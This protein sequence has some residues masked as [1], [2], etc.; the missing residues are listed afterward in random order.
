MFDR[1]EIRVRSGDGG[2]G[3][4]SF[5]REKFAPFGGPDGGDGGRGGNVIIV[6]DASIANLSA[7][8][9][10]RLYRAEKGGHGKGKKKH[11]KNGENLILEVPKGTIALDT[12]RSFDE[13]LLAD[14]EQA[15][16]RVVLAR[17]GKGGLGNPHF[18][19]STNQA[20]RIAQKGD[21]GEELSLILELRLIA[22][23]GVIGFPNAGKSTLLTAASAA[24][25]KIA[26]YS[27]TTLEPAL[28]VVEVGLKS[29]VIAEIPGLIDGAHLG[30]GLGHDFLRHIMRTKIL[31]H[32]IDGS[33][34]ALVDNMILLNRELSL[35][36]PTLARKPQLVVINKIDVPEV[37]ARVPDIKTEFSG[38]GTKV[39][40]ISASVS[41]GITELMTE[42]MEMLSKADAKVEGGKKIHKAVFRPQPRN[43]TASVCKEDDIFIIESPELERIV[44]RVD[45]ANPEVRR[46]LQR[47]LGRL[48]ITR[49]LEKA[50][51]EPGD[52]VRCGDHEWEW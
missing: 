43:V 6:A 26:S 23:V 36:D 49:V 20:P 30:R 13:A 8:N 31:I 7:F 15:G 33:S 35:F 10:N 11:G 16:Q 1:V 45:M 27:F 28:G 47:Q 21:V 12:D 29:F 48:G 2:D 34:A 46:Q 44:A 5:R 18:A 41:E 32:L 42:T 3:T 24:T 51:V 19:S 37:R 50:G 25:P 17:G 14:C 39:F 38:V 9:R 52:V 4:V 40:F 22:D